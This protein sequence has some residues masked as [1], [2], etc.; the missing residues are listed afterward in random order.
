MTHPDMR[1]YEALD[2]ITRHYDWIVVRM[3]LNIIPG[4]K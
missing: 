3:T 1:P 4:I 2:N